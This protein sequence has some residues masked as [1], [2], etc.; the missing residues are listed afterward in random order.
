MNEY[1]QR[2]KYLYLG[3]FGKIVDIDL[4]PELQ[5]HFKYMKPEEVNEFINNAVTDY[6]DSGGR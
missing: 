4:T 5:E 1:I 6:I 3:E 2:F